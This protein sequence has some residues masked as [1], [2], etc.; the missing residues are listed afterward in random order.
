MSL[1]TFKLHKLI[2]KEFDQLYTKHSTKWSMMVARAGESVKACIEDN[3]SVKA[4]DIVAAVKHGIKISKE[5]ED[6]LSDK[7]LTQQYWTEWFAEYIVEQIYP[8]AKINIIKR[9]EG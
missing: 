3:D 7:K 9:K 8:H 6:H 2:G 5:F 1:D 4:G